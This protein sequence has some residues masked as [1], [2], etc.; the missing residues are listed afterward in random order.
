MF[1]MIIIA[2]ILFLLCAILLVAEVFVP[3]FGLISLLALGCLAGGLAIFFKISP[4]AGWTGVVVAVIMVPTT[5]VFAY[6]IFP[7]TSFGKTVTLDGPKKTRGEGVP[8]AEHLS[9]LLGKTAI[10]ISPLRPVGMCDFEGA[11]LECVAESGYVEKGK[12]VKVIKVDGTQLTV[13][14]IEKA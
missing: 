13:R 1:W 4:A 12:T 7:K 5:L 11:K 8:D 3:S 9:T 2:I 14:E 10:V 6:K